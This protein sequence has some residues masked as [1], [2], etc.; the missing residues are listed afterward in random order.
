VTGPHILIPTEA[1]PLTWPSSVKRHPSPQASRFA[2]PTIGNGL[3]EI[4]D[5]LRRLGARSV[6]ISTNLPLRKDGEPYARGLNLDEDQGAAVYWSLAKGKD[7]VPYCLPCDKWRS[8]AE[9]LHA[10]ALT[11]SALRAVERHG[12]IHVVQAFEGF[13][14][15]PPGGGAIVTAP[16]WR[17]VL[18]GNWPAKPDGSPLANEELLGI[19][20]GRFRAFMKLVHPNSA[21]ATVDDDTSARVAE[22]TVARD[23]AEAELCA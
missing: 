5:E 22:L 8:L 1:S 14:A 20:R 2:G 9:N 11:I 6:I 10:I 4:R 17:D 23:A 12:A 18:G 15:L 16:P 7:K 21:G 13:K 3:S 19:V